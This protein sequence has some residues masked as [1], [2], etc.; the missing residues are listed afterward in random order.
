MRILGM[1]YLEYSKLI[2]FIKSKFNNVS[3][4]WTKAM[5]NQQNEYFSNATCNSVC[6]RSIP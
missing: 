6:S 2:Y 3:P 4:D 5:K 1:L